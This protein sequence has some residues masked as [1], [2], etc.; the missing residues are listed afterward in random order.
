MPISSKSVP[1][2]LCTFQFKG[3]GRE[4]FH[5]S[6]CAVLSVV[7]NVFQWRSTSSLIEPHVP[8]DNWARED[9]VSCT[10]IAQQRLLMNGARNAGKDKSRAPEFESA[11]PIGTHEDDHGGAG[12][13]PT[14]VLHTC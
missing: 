10:T 8:R 14:T 1:V 13:S 3:N 5:F 11:G 6:L 9:T 4:C 2:R 12:C 7:K